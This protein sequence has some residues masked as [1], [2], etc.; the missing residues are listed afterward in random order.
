MNYLNEIN[1]PVQNF[2]EPL[3]LTMEVVTNADMDKNYGYSVP[4]TSG[5]GPAWNY[6]DL[7]PLNLTSG[8]QVRMIPTPPASPNNNLC[9]IQEENPLQSA[10]LH[11]QFLAQQQ[12][13]YLNS[14]HAHHPQICLTDVQG[15]EITLVAL[16]D[17]SR[18]SNDSLDSNSEFLKSIFLVLI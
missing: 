1:F 2:N 17:S 13:L 5:Q 18:D 11:K 16:S 7:R 12:E 14:Q 10:L 4:S 15:S 3:D 8:Q 9:I 6:Y